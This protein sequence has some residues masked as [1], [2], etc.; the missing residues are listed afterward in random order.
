MVLLDNACTKNSDGKHRL[1]KWGRRYVCHE[2]AGATTQIQKVDTMVRE[3][4]ALVDLDHEPNAND[5]GP[6]H[7]SFYDVNTR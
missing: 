3:G 7:E 5:D 4:R 6:Y 2:C 1:R